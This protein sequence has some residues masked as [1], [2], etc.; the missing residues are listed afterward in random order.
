MAN[1]ALA[2]GDARQE[3]NQI[4]K[5]A[6]ALHGKRAE[7]RPALG[8]ERGPQ[9]QIDGSRDEHEGHK[10]GRRTLTAARREPTEPLDQGRSEL[11][12]RS[13]DDV[14]PK[15]HCDEP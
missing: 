14:E 5:D 9:R 4:V 8:P 13:R 7:G 3:V 1:P 11:V 12:E 6:A 15:Q 10:Q 2:D